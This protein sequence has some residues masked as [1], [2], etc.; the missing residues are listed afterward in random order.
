MSFTNTQST[1]FKVK[2]FNFSGSF[3]IP[4]FYTLPQIRTRCQ[5]FFTAAGIVSVTVIV[6]AQAMSCIAQ[7]FTI[8]LVVMTF[9]LGLLEYEVIWLSMAKE[10]GAGRC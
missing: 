9:V 2:W 5:L 8:I 7:I 6:G 3:F 4:F 10:D 1:S